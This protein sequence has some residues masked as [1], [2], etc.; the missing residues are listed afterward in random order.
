MKKIF[1]LFLTAM[2]SF[3]I[4]TGCSKSAGDAT[5]I[6]QNGAEPESLDPALISGVPE[7]RIYMS[8][9]E[10]LTT[11]D[12][13]TADPIPGLAKSWDVSKDGKTYTF[14]L[15]DAVWSDGTPI[16][17]QTFVDSWL[18]FL[19][20]ETAAKYAWMMT[21]IVAGADD[22]NSGKAGP[23]AVKIKAVD[24]KTF[25]VTLT[26][27]A[28]YFIGMAAHYAFSIQPLHVIKKHGSEWTNVENFVSNGPFKLSEWKPQEKIVCVPNE[29]YWDK[30]NVSLKEVVYLPMEDNNTAMNMYVNGELD[31]CTRIPTDR[32]EEGKA[33]DGYNVNPILSTYYYVFNTKRKPFDDPR[34]RKA[35]SMSISRKDIVEKITREGQIP[36][37]AMV[38]PMGTYKPSEGN[39]ENIEEAKKLLAEAGYEGGKG[40]DTITILYNTD[41][42][43]K[44]IA[45]YVQQQWEKNLGVKV[46]L[47]NQEWKTYLKTREKGEFDVAR[48]G[49]VGDYQDPNTF[50]ELF[51]STSSMNGGKWNNPEFDALIKKATTISDTKKR[52]ETL[53]KA[54]DLLMKKD[55]AVMA[56]YYYSQ[57]NL[58]DSDKWGGWYTNT[59]DV[60]PTKNI[61][62]K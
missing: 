34:V 38:P 8:L 35:F 39:P 22:Y 45:E 46:D 33:L 54:E 25:Q 43:H 58:I 9:F 40:I 53:R 59:M 44:K 21:M 48:A 50:L 20:P 7:H 55:Q 19:N 56:F 47:E 49:W 12:P 42:N 17:A 11:Y 1:F 26:G 31:W 29:N 51:I 28:P 61:Y 3:A 13:E 32:V 5:F 52:L 2:M 36:T 60:H 23:E 37:V 57:S 6:I 18:R 16:T 62:R 30:S 41:E 24:D 27:P 14:H 15:R 10:G 4:M